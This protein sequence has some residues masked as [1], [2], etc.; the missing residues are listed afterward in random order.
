MRNRAALHLVWRLA[1][2]ASIV[3]LT[4]AGS[5]G[6]LVGSLLTLLGVQAQPTDPRPPRQ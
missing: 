4:L 6:W 5:P 2:L 3:G 1:V